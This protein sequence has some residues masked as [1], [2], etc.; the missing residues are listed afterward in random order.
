MRLP[1]S[2]AV[3]GG[4]GGQ[5]DRNNGKGRNGTHTDGAESESFERLGF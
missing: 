1:S 4:E 3:V 2:G 5:R